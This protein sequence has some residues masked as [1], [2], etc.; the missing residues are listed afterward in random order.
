MAD[1]AARIARLEA[2][3]QQLRDHHADEIERRDRA[4]VEAVE[5]QTATAEVLQVIARSPI[6]QQ[7]VLDT[8]VQSVTRLCQA[9]NAVIYRREGSMLRSV[10][11]HG[12]IFEG[13]P[14]V[15]P[16]RSLDPMR[17]EG[18]AVLD[19]RIIHVAD[20][21]SDEEGSLYPTSRE[22]SRRRGWRSAVIAPLVWEG[23]AIGA[24]DIFRRAIG[25]FSE[26]QIMLLETFADQAVIAIENARLF[27]AL[28]RRNADL[29]ESLEQQTATAEVLRVIASSPS[30]LQGVLDTIARSAMQLVGGTRVALLLRE[31]DHLIRLVSLRSDGDPLQAIGAT[32]P[33][34]ARIDVCASVLEHRTI[35]HP[36]RSDPAVLEEFPDTQI[37]DPVA[38]VTVPLM[39]KHDAIGAMSVARD[40]R[41]AYSAREIA[42]V[43]MFADQVVIA[44]ENSR[45]FTELKQANRQLAEA[46]GHKSQFLANMSHELRTPLN[47][48]IGYSEMLHEELEELGHV[49]LVPDVEKINAAGRHLLGLIND[50]LDLSK[51]EAGKM[52]LFLDLIDVEALVRE[53][54]ATVGPLV[55]RN[56][57]TLVVECPDAIGEMHADATKLRQVLFN[58]LGNAAKFTERGTITVTATRDAADW[59]TFTVADTG[60]GMTEEQLGR[61]FRAFTQAEASTTRRFGGTGLG[62]TLVRHFVEMMGGDVRVESRGGAGSA[63]AVRLPAVVPAPAPNSSDP[64]AAADDDA[65]APPPGSGAE[66]APVVLVIDDDPTARELLRRQLEADDVRVVEAAAGEEGLSLARQLRPALITLDVL[67]P[68]MDG[69][70]V[71]G[72]LKGDPTTAEIPVILLTML[73]DRDLGYALGAA[74]YLT[75]PIDRDRLVRAVGKHVHRSDGDASRR[76]LIV[77]DDAATREM[78]RRLLQRE[79]W[80]VRGAAN[81]RTGLEQVAAARPDVILLDLMMPELDGFEFVERLH[82]QPRWRTIPVLVITA[83]DLTSQERLRL[84]GRVEQVLRKGA[85]SRGELLAEVRALV[86]TSVER[87]AT[88]EPPR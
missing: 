2:E 38:N 30:N 20:I 67:M 78:L 31:D 3:L 74:D 56:G 45:L 58:L 85:Y 84:N 73:E 68:G 66:D 21:L 75:K 88:G 63:F 51:I 29:A 37:R 1:D 27:E 82:A 69:W 4:L 7:Q 6:D 53:V 79:G 23:S 39:R 40:A 61:L 25:P 24:I 44:I 43:E 54:A 9:E 64:R 13:A 33:L 71:L 47:A 87:T 72:A 42:L 83:K 36:D 52:E 15:T 16:Y 48:V 49:A 62:L 81:G 80:A 22:A 55:A 70:A 28:E 76:A 46:S 19:A 35:H 34:T 60:I 77:E 14:P 11:R 18:R 65:D 26:Q 32:L 86:R 10:A 12:P 5:Q 17:I 59:L 8:I 57:N 50:I 41:H